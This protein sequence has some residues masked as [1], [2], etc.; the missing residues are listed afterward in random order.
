MQ[1]LKRFLPSKRFSNSSDY[2][3]EGQT[4]QEAIINHAYCALFQDSNTRKN[5]MKLHTLESMEL[6][7]KHCYH[8]C[9]NEHNRYWALLEY[10]N[11]ASRLMNTCVQ[12]FQGRASS[13]CWPSGQKNYMATLLRY[14]HSRYNWWLWV[15]KLIIANC[16][17]APKKITTY[18]NAINNYLLQVLNIFRSEKPPLHHE[19]PK[20]PVKIKHEFW[21]FHRKLQ[22]PACFRITLCC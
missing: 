8:G 9:T 17:N 6:H 2:Q 11:R 15:K 7:L 18:G 22:L 1:W 13:I 20:K 3:H 4:A 14:A 5:L 21:I 16:K 12:M 19:L 10:G